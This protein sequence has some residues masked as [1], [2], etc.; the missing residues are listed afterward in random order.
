M[1]NVEYISF[2]NKCVSVRDESLGGH[3]VRI[4]ACEDSYVYIPCHVESLLIS[5]CVNCTI[6]VA[7]TCKITTVEKCE[8]TIIVNA[9]NLMRIGNCVD[10]T[11][12]SYTVMSAPIIYGD[13]RSQTMAPHNTNYQDFAR[14]LIAAGIKPLEQGTKKSAKEEEQIMHF[15]KPVIMGN[16]VNCFSLMSPVDF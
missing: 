14:S 11:M 12:H 6:F 3:D 8:G 7:A 9:S 5:N 16:K 2:L 10:C 15:S 13:T 1:A 4:I